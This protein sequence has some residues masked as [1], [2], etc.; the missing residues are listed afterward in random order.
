MS[1]WIPATDDV[2]KRYTTGAP[3]SA[4]SRSPEARREAGE[5]FDRWLERVKVEAKA[6]GWDEAAGA[7]AEQGTIQIP[8]NPYQA[9]RRGLR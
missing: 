4:L 6:E 3:G 2:R 5:G 7:I 8:E 1:G 9:W